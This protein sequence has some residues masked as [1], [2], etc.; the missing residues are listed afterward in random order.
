M[1]RGVITL[2]TDFG[3]RDGYVGTMKGVI[4]KIN[5]LVRLVDITHD[6]SPQ[7]IFEAGFILKN[8][9]R[10]FPDKSIHLVVVDPGVG[11]KRR[12]IIIEAGNHFFIGPDNGVFTFIYESEK[13]KKVVELTNKKYFLPYISNT[14][15]GRDIF[16]PA[17]AYLSKGAPFEEF[18]EICNDVVRFDIPEPETEKGIIKGVVLHVDRFGNLI[19]NIPEVLFRELVGKGMYEIS[20]AGE[21]LGDIK[22]SYSEAKE[23]QALALFG[24]SGYLEISVR[25]RNAQEKLKVNKG[26]EI[27]VVY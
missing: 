5:P 7:D 17:A 3:T 10:Y 4:L 20:I 27:K 11:S 9:Y 15:H 1:D 22:E 26:S 18:G 25:G 2:I 19:S 8:S 6:I 14:F 12:A 24:S 21:V 16:A 13:I 23:E